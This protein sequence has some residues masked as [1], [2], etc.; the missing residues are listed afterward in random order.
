MNLPTSIVLQSNL[1]EQAR[2]ELFVDQIC[3]DY[4]IGNTYFGHILLSLTEAFENAIRHGNKNDSS[5]KVTISLQSTRKG[6]CFSVAD[7]GNGFDPDQV[8]DPTNPDT[9][10]SFY[11]GRGLYT[12]RS[13]S[14]HLRFSNRGQTVHISFYVSSM[15]RELSDMRVNLLSAYYNSK[16]VLSNSHQ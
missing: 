4:N 1:S 11:Q 15:N 6:L 16:P 3:E 14:D 9:P 10:E 12:I 5:K 8:A 7:E 13:I 2:L